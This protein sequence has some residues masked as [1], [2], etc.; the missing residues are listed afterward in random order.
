MDHTRLH[1]S[2]TTDGLQ[3]RTGIQRGCGLVGVVSLH[4][5]FDGLHERRAYPFPHP[6]ACTLAAALPSVYHMPA[7][8]YTAWSGRPGNKR[9]QYATEAVHA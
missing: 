4:D 9:I 8:W 6:H 2:Y 3:T 1:T 7:A 5:I